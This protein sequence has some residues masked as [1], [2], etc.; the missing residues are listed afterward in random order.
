MKIMV[1][2]LT[3]IGV[4]VVA[5]AQTTTPAT[6]PL[7]RHYREGETVTYHM[8][9]NNDGRHYT[10][11]ATGVVEKTPAGRYVVPFRWT[12][13]NYEGHS[14]KL[15][16]AMLNL[17]EPLSLDPRSTPSMPDLSSIDPRMVGPITDLATFYIDDWLADK[18]NVLHR[19]GD[20]VHIPNPQAGSWADGAHVLIG[21]SY[22]DFDLKLRSVNEA[23]HTAVLVVQHVPPSHLNVH[24][25]ALWM[26]APVADT[27]NNWIQVS[28]TSDGKYRAGIGKE[29]FDVSIK[30]STVNGEILSATMDNLVVTSTRVCTNA[31]LTRCG[32]P[33]RQTIH[34][35][36][37]I[38]LQP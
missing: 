26:R 10:A 31:E 18:L 8:V 14:V 32:S 27:P 4:S 30:V 12:K 24:L 38:A 2:A 11:D 21:K 15:A 23:N 33:E 37:Q 5:L 17:R 1:S 35:R 13:L 3:L 6:G 34:R 36:I 9:A 29:T 20:H 16:P 19:P 28:K 25:P 7:T 22:V